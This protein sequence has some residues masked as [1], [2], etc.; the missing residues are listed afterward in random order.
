MANWPAA[1]R[2]ANVRGTTKIKGRK[3]AGANARRYPGCR[4]ADSRT[5]D[6]THARAAHRIRRPDVARAA[7]YARARAQLR[8]FPADF[9]RFVATEPA[10]LRGR[11]VLRA[12]RSPGDHR[13][14]CELRAA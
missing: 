13:A 2:P 1:P 6:R 11:A 14:R 4:G 9:R 8:R 12:R 5:T 3:G 10:V 7:G